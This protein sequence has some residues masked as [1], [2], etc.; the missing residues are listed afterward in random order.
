ME[1]NKRVSVLFIFLIVLI[2]VFIANIV[3]LF[4]KQ[5]PEKS[6]VGENISNN[7]NQATE[8]LSNFKLIS[9]SENEGIDE[10]LTKYAKSQNIDLEIEYAEDKDIVDMLNSG[11][12]YDAVWVSDSIW[13]NMLEDTVHIVDAK[14]TSINPIVLAIKEDIAENLGFTKNDIYFKDIVE[15][16]KDG[17]LNICMADPTQTNT[18]ISTYLYFI[19]IISGTPGVLKSEYLENQ[20]VK[21]ELVSIFKVVEESSSENILEKLFLNGDY[22]A[23]ITYESSIISINQELES[24]G[25]KIIY[26]LYPKDGVYVS[27]SP[28]AYIDN[29]DS[30]KKAVFEK[31]QEFI[32]SDDSQE[33]LSSKGRRAW[34]GGISDFANKNI[35][36]L[37]WGIDTTKYITPINFQ[38]IETIKKFIELYQSELSEK[39]DNA[40]IENTELENTELENNNEENNIEYS[41]NTNYL[42]SSEEEILNSFME[43]VRDIINEET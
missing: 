22:N 5:E 10:F 24:N 39:I 30:E 34:Y 2:I 25:D 15:K 19:S 42:G 41:D 23:I 8:E 27:N 32:L 21:N 37:S 20:E 11:E 17:S 14:S 3:N 35:F 31:L 29:E 36:K 12:K 38:D 43:E 40:K 7:N 33:M 16:I 9:S 28:F 6:A 26:A 18:G 1:G 4:K 13:L